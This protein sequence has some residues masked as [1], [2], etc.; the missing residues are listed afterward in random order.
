[1]RDFLH[2][3]ERRAAQVEIGAMKERVAGGT[4]CVTGLRASETCL[5]ESRFEVIP[6]ESSPPQ[7]YPSAV[8]V[9]PGAAEQK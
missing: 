1:M 7:I 2:A 9:H 3:R 4:V 8:S 5:G 6:R